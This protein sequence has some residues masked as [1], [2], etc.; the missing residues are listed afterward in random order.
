[1][2]NVNYNDLIIPTSRLHKNIV[3][4]EYWDGKSSYF[5]TIVLSSPI[6][7]ILM[8]YDMYKSSVAFDKIARVRKL[9]I[10]G[11]IYTEE[12]NVTSMWIRLLSLQKSK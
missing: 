9:V 11:A 8:S 6:S 10:K 1:M 2:L 7:V 5:Y 12:K 3:K 4:M